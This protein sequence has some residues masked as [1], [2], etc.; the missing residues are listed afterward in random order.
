M[1]TCLSRQNVRAAA[2]L[3]ASEHPTHA[4]HPHSNTRHKYRMP[5]TAD[6]FP[7]PLSLNLSCS[8][9][10]DRTPSI[11]CATLHQHHNYTAHNDLMFTF[12]A[13]KVSARVHRSAYA[14][15]YTMYSEA[16]LA[17]HIVTSVSLSCSEQSRAVLCVAASL[18]RTSWPL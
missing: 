15:A 8:P 7:L 2:A 4:A 11:L 12:N 1:Y 10:V 14:Y 6:W 9:E 17:N 5:M 3:D 13:Y 16:N 18:R